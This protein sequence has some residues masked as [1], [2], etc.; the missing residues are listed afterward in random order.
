MDPDLPMVL[1][2]AGN[3]FE[4]D[5]YEGAC[6]DHGYSPFTREAPGDEVCVAKKKPG[7]LPDDHPAPTS[8]LSPMGE[9]TGGASF[10]R[11]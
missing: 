9:K 8:L 10:S 1:D 5:E 4:Q 7:D 6:L 2:D 3:F 11:R